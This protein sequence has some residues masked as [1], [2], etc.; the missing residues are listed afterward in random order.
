MQSPGRLVSAESIKM[1]KRVI[2]MVLIVVV[3]F[4]LSWLP[5]HVI[6][7]LRALRMY[8]TTPALISLQ[9]ISQI[10]AYSNSC[11]NPILYAFLSE[12]FR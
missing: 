1:K 11:V 2:K 12:P 3:L 7:L 10:F 6:L 9:V 5:I 8:S 4:A